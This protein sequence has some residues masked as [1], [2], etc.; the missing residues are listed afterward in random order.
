VGN[1][2][3]DGWNQFWGAIPNSGGISAVLAIFGGAIMAFFLVK[4]F[5]QKSRGG[6]GGALQGF[7]WWPMLVGLLLTA[8]AF[9]IPAVLRVVQVIIGLV[10]TLLTTLTG[11]LS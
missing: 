7:P 10:D 5:W 4:W 11:A 2:L 1:Q 3:V 9:L 8:P 6:G